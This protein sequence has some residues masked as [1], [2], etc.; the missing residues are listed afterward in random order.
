MLKKTFRHPPGPGAPRRA[1]HRSFVLAS[2]RGSTFSEKV[3]LASSLAAA[4]SDGLLNILW[5][6]RR[7]PAPLKAVLSP[8]HSECHG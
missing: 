7:Q 8:W 6:I 2:L 1:I 5:L 3:R 4:L